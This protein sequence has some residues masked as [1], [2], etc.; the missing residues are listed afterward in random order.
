VHLRLDE[1]AVYAVLQQ[2]CHPEPVDIVP[3]N[4][5]IERVD[6]P[7]RPIGLRERPEKGVL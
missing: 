1:P 3:D 4:S 6:L 2:P 5:R 7:Q